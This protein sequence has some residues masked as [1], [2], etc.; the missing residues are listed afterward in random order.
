[1]N[2]HLFLGE[3][4]IP[5]H[6]IR[7]LRLMKI[8]LSMTLALLTVSV[9]A[10]G[11]AGAAAPVIPGNTGPCNGK[12]E[13]SHRTDQKEFYQLLTY[14]DNVDLNTKL[15]AW[16]SFYNYD[17]PHISLEGKTPYEVMMSLLK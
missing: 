4:E 11:V 6:K 8:I 5:P 15:K 17:R 2:A 13:G 14:T 1:M 10:V 12:V 16:E 7:R 9:I 3:E